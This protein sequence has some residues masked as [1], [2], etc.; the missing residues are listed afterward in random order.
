MLNLRG[1]KLADFLY[2]MFISN[3][4][5]RVFQE[6]TTNIIKHAR[7]QYVWI[8]LEVDAKTV[9]LTLADDGVGFNADTSQRDFEGIGIYNMRQRIESHQ[10]R[11]DISSSEAGTILNMNIPMMTQFGRSKLI[12]NKEIA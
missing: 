11:L 3:T 12:M 6:A 1:K 4:L 5:F 10:G 9:I 2:Q 7:A 8:A